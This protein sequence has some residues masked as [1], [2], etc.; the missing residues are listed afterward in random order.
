MV[1]QIPS[2]SR[3]RRD[4]RSDLVWMPAQSTCICIRNGC[5]L[6]AAEPPTNRKEEQMTTFKIINKEVNIT[7]IVISRHCR[8]NF[9]RN[10][11]QQCLASLLLTAWIDRDASKRRTQSRAF[12]GAG[13]VELNICMHV[14][15]HV[16][17]MRRPRT[18]VY[19][20][21]CVQRCRKRPCRVMS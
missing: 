13:G 3:S 2:M 5:K 14:G 10:V 21:A 1:A 20:L 16:R 6:I 12:D 19:L 8:R 4:L 11:I 18:V 9:H 15:G 7:D 17:P